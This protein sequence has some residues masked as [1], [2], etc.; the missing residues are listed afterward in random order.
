MNLCNDL[1]NIVRTYLS[2]KSIS[3]KDEDNAEDLAAL[4]C[5]MRIRHIGPAPRSVHF[6][7]E[8]H[9]TLG[10]LP[11]ETD[12]QEREKALDAWGTV[13]RLRYVFTNG[14]DLAPYLSGGIKDA[15]SPDGLLW[16]YGM[17]HFH[18][19]SSVGKSGFVRRS[20][21]LLFAI[22]THD[23]AF[24]VDV[25]KHRDP[26][27]LQWVRQDLLTVVHANWPEITSMFALHGVDGSTLTDEQKKEL[28][29]KNINTV[30]DFY[31]YA[32]AP[33]GGGTTGDGGSVWCRM[34]ADRLLSEIERH[35]AIL[36]TQPDEVRAALEAK[37]L[38]AGG[39]MDFRLVPL[40]NID[41]SPEIV[42]HL[43]EGNHSSGRLYA[44]GLGIVE[45][46]SGC[47]VVIA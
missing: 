9:N 7:S 16:D 24:F 1:K 13:F 38:A 8:L 25:R 28:R 14:G 19:S 34:W 15:R 41:A 31:E 27:N 40:D 21:Y 33:L 36:V 35:E 3:Y 12:P 29:G 10:S 20:D 47:P 5:E 17:H 26:Q 2:E 46:A 45:A 43:Q 44:L 6:S 4:Y 37:G 11:N 23:H 22:V 42:E 30:H 39:V 32:T 18:L